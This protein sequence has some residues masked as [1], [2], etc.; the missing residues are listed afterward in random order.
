LLMKRRL[1]NFPLEF[2]LT[3]AKLLEI[4]Y[5]TMM[6]YFGLRMLEMGGEVR[7]LYDRGGS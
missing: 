7:W 1:K 3:V 5:N 4:S 6:K 2:V